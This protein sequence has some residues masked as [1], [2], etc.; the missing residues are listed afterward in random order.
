MIFIDN[1]YTRIY[2][3]IIDRGLH[4]S[5]E[6][7]KEK[8]HII[9]RS[10]GG[11]D[12]KDNLVCLTAREH[13]IVHWLLIK[14][15][16]NED[17][18]KMIYAFWRMTTTG[19]Y[20]VTSRT[21]SM[22]KKENSTVHSLRMTGENNPFFGK[23]HSPEMIESIKTRNRMQKWSDGRKESW[24][25]RVSGENNPM[26]GRRHTKESLDKMR[27]NRKKVS[28][29]HEQRQAISNRLKGKHV[30]VNERRIE[31]PHCNRTFDLG[32]ARRYHFDRC[33]KR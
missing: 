12:G 25:G 5:L 29:T 21:Y 17:R 16:T 23:Q 18:S 30:K 14:M 7:Y 28:L 19:K 26:Y 10:L 22:I 24:K 11:A 33:K 27:Q 3:Q 15:T 6:G 32:N 13:Y 31:C 1:K 2:Y 9:P 4:R 20:R 8:H